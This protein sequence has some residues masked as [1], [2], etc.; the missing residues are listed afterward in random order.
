MSKQCSCEEILGRVGF[1][2]QG[3][4]Q[5]GDVFGRELGGGGGQIH[6]CGTGEN[7][8][9]L[10]TQYFM[11]QAQVPL[12]CHFEHWARS[13][14][15]TIQVQLYIHRRNLVAY[16]LPLDL[17]LLRCFLILINLY[18]IKSHNLKFNCN[19]MRC[20]LEIVISQYS[21]SSSIQ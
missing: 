14:C 7:S 16:Q 19:L 15:C 6:Q 10:N 5:G 13:H 2:G 12:S 3:R 21:L 11:W 17:N 18:L 20:S 4:K 8:T 9:T 1:V